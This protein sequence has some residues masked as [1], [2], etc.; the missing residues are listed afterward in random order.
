MREDPAQDEWAIYFDKNNNGL[1]STQTG[2]R[3]IGDDAPEMLFIELWRRERQKTQAVAEEERLERL[4][5][6]REREEKE[7]DQ[8]I[9]D[10]RVEEAEEHARNAE[11]IRKEEELNYYHGGFREEIED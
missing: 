10:G 8:A 7:R 5:K 1:R 9:E 4:Q 6:R 3:R 11:D 2:Q